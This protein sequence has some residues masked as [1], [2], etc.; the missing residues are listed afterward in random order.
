ME[1]I[2]EKAEEEGK[3]DRN[4]RV[5]TLTR[6]RMNLH[7]LN[8]DR[9]RVPVLLVHGHEARIAQ[10]FL[11]QRCLYPRAFSACRF[12]RRKTEHEEVLKPRAEINVV[13][14]ESHKVGNTRLDQMLSKNVV[15]TRQSHI[16][17]NELCRKYDTE[18]DVNFI[19]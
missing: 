9:E 5:L 19:I 10:N 18:T 3:L 14:L 16:A 12:A 8:L 17:S 2:R 6:K 15:N 4:D 13:C 1:I 7:R 11:G